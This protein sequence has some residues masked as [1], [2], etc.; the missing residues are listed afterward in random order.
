MKQLA[1]LSK[2]SECSGPED[3]AL[4]KYRSAWTAW[5]YLCLTLAETLRS[6]RRPLALRLSA[7]VFFISWI[8][9]I[10]CL[11][12]P[13]VMVCQLDFQKCG[14]SNSKGKI[15]RQECKH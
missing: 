5:K 15:R 13:I 9:R 2:S 6:L 8:W 7:R 11:L 1:A 14:R 12:T 4:Q 10:D 3:V